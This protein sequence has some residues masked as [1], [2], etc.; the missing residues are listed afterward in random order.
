MGPFK[1][2]FPIR[3]NKLNFLVINLGPLVP[4]RLR[5]LS[6]VPFLSSP[7]FQ[8][9]V[10]GF[11][12]IITNSLEAMAFFQPKFPKNLA[13]LV[14]QTLLITSPKTFLLHFPLPLGLGSNFLVIIPPY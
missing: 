11:Q 7:I 10:E 9:W 8:L 3:F 1:P 6:K 13:K 4:R 12:G 2:K 14:G 5:D